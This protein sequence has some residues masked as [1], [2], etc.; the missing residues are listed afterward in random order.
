[1]KRPLFTLL[2]VG[3]I[4]NNPILAL[5]Q[6][7]K[8]QLVVLSGLENQHTFNAINLGLEKSRPDWTLIS[9][10][11]FDTQN[12]G[13]IGSYTLEMNE[14]QWL[15]HE[16]PLSSRTEVVN[17]GVLSVDTK[18]GYPQETFFAFHGSGRIGPNDTCGQP[19]LGKAL[20]KSRT[21]LINFLIRKLPSC[22]KA[23]KWEENNQ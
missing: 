8:C 19:A 12:S 5:A 7:Q 22:N 15:D 3:L 10:A 16:L 1:M 6:T 18:Q 9:R 2:L 23:K 20:E 21:K 11:N 17:S 4:S 14:E 13:Y